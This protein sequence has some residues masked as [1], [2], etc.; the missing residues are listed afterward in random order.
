M[1]DKRKKSLMQI[2][3]IFVPELH[4]NVKFKIIPTEDIEAFVTT[5]LDVLQLELIVEESATAKFMFISENNNET[6]ATLKIKF[7]NGELAL[8]TF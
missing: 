8:I 5:L 3:Q 2:Y 6:K 1:Q 4:A 7:F